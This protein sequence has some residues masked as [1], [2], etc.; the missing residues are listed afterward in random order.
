VVN[1]Y[2]GQL[3]YKGSDAAK[4][5]QDGTVTVFEPWSILALELIDGCKT[6]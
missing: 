3:K 5:F 6:S 2:L 1:G 4:R